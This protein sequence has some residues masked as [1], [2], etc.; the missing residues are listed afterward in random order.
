MHLTIDMCGAVRFG[1]DV[2]WVDEVDYSIDSAKRPPFFEQIRKYWPTAILKNCRPLT[3]AFAL[4]PP[5][6]E[7]CSMIFYFSRKVMSPDEDHSFARH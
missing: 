6:M 3:Q 1:P 4:K 7:R 5:A 2:T